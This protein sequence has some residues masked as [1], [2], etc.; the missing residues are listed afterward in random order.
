MQL[1]KYT[2]IGPRKKNEDSVE[3]K[4]INNTVYAAIADGVGGI[5]HGEIASSESVK[6]FFENIEGTTKLPFAV[7]LEQANL[8]L[9]LIAKNQFNME[10]I[11]TTFTGLYANKNRIK[12]I[13]IGDTRAILI[14]DGKIIRL[15]EDHNLAGRILR[16]NKVEESSSERYGKNVLENMLGNKKLFKYQEFNI[17]SMPKD[18][19]IMSTDGFHE[20]IN[21]EIIIR[22]SNKYKSIERVFQRLIIELENSILRD[23]A[24]FI[25]IEI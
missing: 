7:F 10:F 16:E 2:N 4:Q 23:N 14:R 24:S 19:V 1:F 8:Q 3:A 9:E 13:H 6:L 17:N 5:A 21:E 18:R 25:C 20:S 11:G 12:G 15:T 22:I